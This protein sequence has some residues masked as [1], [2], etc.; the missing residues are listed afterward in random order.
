MRRFTWSLVVLALGHLCLASPSRADEVEAEEARLAFE[1]AVR[2]LTAYYAQG[3]LQEQD[4]VV[5]QPEAQGTWRIAGSERLS[6]GVFGGVFGSLHEYPTFIDDPH[7]PLDHLYEVD[8][9]VGLTFDVGQL[10]VDTYYERSMS[11]SGAFDPYDIWM[12][13]A[14]YDDSGWAPD[15]SLQPWVSLYVELANSLDDLDPGVNLAF[16]IE[17]TWTWSG[18]RLGDLALRFPL[19]ASLSLGD[20]YQDAAGRDDPFGYVACGIFL[21]VPLRCMPGD[22][23]LE[24][25]ATG[26]FFGQ[27]LRE[28]NE[29]SDDTVLSVGLTFSF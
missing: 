16:G 25:G 28:Y 18:T 23:T 20:F 15:F 8:V 27:S 24:L 14:S 17:P 26:M 29:R 11:P 13:E 21:D 3:F 9:S 7:G 22:A 6:A 4:G 12:L 19:A 5:F 1:G 2:V 10:T